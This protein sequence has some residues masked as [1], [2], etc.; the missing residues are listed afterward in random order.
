MSILSKKGILSIYREEIGSVGVIPGTVK[1]STKDELVAITSPGYLNGANTEGVQILPTDIL[2]CAYGPTLSLK[3]TFNP[4]FA[5]NGEITLVVLGGGGSING[6]VNLGVGDGLLGVSGANITGKSLIAGANISLT[7]TGTDVTIAAVGAGGGTITDIVDVGVGQGHLAA[8]ASGSNVQVKT[9][10]EGSGIVI[11]ENSTTVTIAAV[12]PPGGLTTLA[13]LPGGEGIYTTTVGTTAQLKSIAAGAGIDVSSTPDTIVITNVG[14]GGGNFIYQDTYWLAK[15]GNDANDGLSI[16]TP[17]LTLLNIAALLTTTPT[18][19]NIVDD[20][21]YALPSTFTVSCP[22]LINGPGATIHWTGAGSGLMFF[23][24]TF[25]PLIIG[26]GQIINNNANIFRG[27]SSIICNCPIVHLTGTIRIWE[28][29]FSISP[30][31]VPQAIFNISVSGSGSGGF[32]FKYSGDQIINATELG[33]GQINSQ[34]IPGTGTVR[35]YANSYDGLLSGVADYEV[36]VSNLGPSFNYT[37]TGTVTGAFNS[38]FGGI[39]NTPINLAGNIV[40]AGYQSNIVKRKIIPATGT[41]IYLDHTMSGAEIVLTDNTIIVGLQAYAT[42][43]NYPQGFY[44]DLVQDFATSGCEISGVSATDIFIRQPTSYPF[45]TGRGAARVYLAKNATFVGD[46]NIWVITGDVFNT[47]LVTQTNVFISQ[48]EGTDATANGNIDSQFAT[49]NAALA[50]VIATYTATPAHGINLFITDDATYNE[51]LDFTGTSNIN[52]IGR[53]AQLIYSGAGDAITVNN[54]IFI[55]LARLGAT[56]GGNAL[57]SNDPSFSNAVIGNIDSVTNGAVI[58]NG[59]S[60]IFLQSFALLTALTITGGGQIR[61]ETLY[62]APGLD[63]AGVVGFSPDGA[64]QDWTVKRNLRTDTNL[65]VPST[66]VSVLVA[67]ITITGAILAD[68]IMV[69]NNAGPSTWTLDTAANLNAA[70]PGIQSND[71]FS[72]FVSNATGGTITF[73][74]SAGTTVTG[75]PTAASS[76]TFWMRYVGGLWELYY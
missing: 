18:V 60:L 62:R 6:A 33:T 30:Q 74:N 27:F 52:L 22:L 50:Y 59:N 23:L 42:E 64:S 67:N 68:R 7:P 20:G 13:N 46:P 2:E 9:L 17:K 37:T 65:F 11:T 29:S 56:G 72:V 12:P 8:G 15:N 26:V 1:F 44:V 48:I 10:V 61:Y 73:A 63:G 19:I 35:I 36:N 3:Q 32:V 4:V 47:N 76:F 16:N 58:N 66:P 70:Y 57:V 28:D 43:P 25:S 38:T 24:N 5:A 49:I 21:D 53:E 75:N 39:I 31:G 69:N 54:L 55:A 51:K 41:T 45:Y 71:S 14:A 34:L 40:G